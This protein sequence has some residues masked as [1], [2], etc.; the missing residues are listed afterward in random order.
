MGAV[1]E[2]L[3]TRL[4]GT[5]A[6]KVIRAMLADDPQ[7]ALRFKRE[8]RLAT[9][10]VHANVVRALDSGDDDGFL[11]FAM[12][13][14]QGDTLR[15]RLDSRGRMSWQ[16]T[17][18]LVD[19]MVSALAAAHQLGVIHRDLKPEN[20]M[21]ISD[22]GRLKAKLI[23]FGV[24]KQTHAAAVG[25]SHMTGT[26]LIVGTPGYVAPETV[27]EGTTDDPR[28]DFYALGV[29]WFEMLTGQAP[30]SAKT[31]IALAM[32]HAHE[33]APTPTSL[34]PFAPVPAPIEALVLPLIAKVPSARPTTAVELG[35]L[36][37][38]LVADSR[39]SL[40]LS[41]AVLRETDPTVTDLR[42]KRTGVVPF[43]T[44]HLDPETAP[45]PSVRAAS[46]TANATPSSLLAS[47][48]PPE[49]LRPLPRSW[50]VLAALTLVVAVV[51][52][53]VATR[54]SPACRGAGDSHGHDVDCPPRPAG[55]GDYYALPVV[56]QSDGSWTGEIPGSYTRSKKGIVI[57]YL[58]SAFDLQGDLI[59]TWGNHGAPKTIEVKA[60]SSMALDLKAN[61]RLSHVT[62]V[63][64][65][66]VVTPL[67]TVGVGGIASVLAMGTD[68]LMFEA[69][70]VQRELFLVAL[71]TPLGATFGTWVAVNSILD[72]PAALV[73]VLT[74][75]TL[76]SIFALGV[77]WVNSASPKP[78]DPEAHSALI[79]TGAAVVML[80]SSAVPTVL[81][82]WDEPA[83]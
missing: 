1:Y 36:L 12:E 77:F 48:S 25:D 76:A 7:V 56:K 55:G 65:A 40:T 33:P 34:V 28:S 75:A 39:R 59:T 80:A 78:K 60:G 54:L 46:I 44:P 16:E 63:G 43:A 11:W 82:A 71:L 72:A 2:A 23:D 69:D 41:P 8:I 6:V 61:E 50:R 29:T 74:T 70:E 19:D 15:A 26:G 62:R 81:V 4:G 5:V 9:E 32:R 38:N 57:E 3:D 14:L 47:T 49:L 21:L 18:P 35:V 67:M 30:F 73:P 79:I 24:A 51:A 68:K 20:I 42:G 66:A 45:D 53:I 52:A 37:S 31:P 58:I 17:L 64:L 27:L 13:L 83:E 22:E 10:I